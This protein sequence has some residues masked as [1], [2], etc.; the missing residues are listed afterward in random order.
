MNERAESGAE[1]AAWDGSEGSLRERLRREG[2]ASRGPASRHVFDPEVWGLWHNG[3]CEF[4]TSIKP[5]RL[6]YG[7]RGTR[8]EA[9]AGQ[10]HFLDGYKGEEE[11]VAMPYDP[12]KKEDHLKKTK[13]GDCG[14]EPG[15]LH[16]AGCDVERCRCCGGQQIGC[17]CLYDV[18]G[19]DLDTMEKEYPEIYT[20][21]ATDEMYEKFDAHVEA[22]GG[23]LPW[24]GIWPGTEECIEFGLWSRHVEGEDPYWQKCG[25]DD[26]G[27]GPDLNRLGLGC[28]WD[29][30]TGRWKLAP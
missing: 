4:K 22:C 12:Y 20:K 19:L 18:N 25:P 3:W 24:T 26:E 28:R 23:R 29:V 7:Q 11:Y 8:E 27:A 10:V 6:G 30:K 16:Q 5:D 17:D 9:L 21:G 13:C 2:L 15:E 1:S 14:A